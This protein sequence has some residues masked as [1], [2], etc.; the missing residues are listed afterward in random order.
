MQ[1]NLNSTRY[2]ALRS[3]LTQLQSAPKPDVAAIDDV[4]KQLAD[5][6]LHLKA[7]DG[8]AGNNPI[9]GKSQHKR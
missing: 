8:Q 4:I 9:E 2:N 7:L 6:Q 5:E 3:R 1:D